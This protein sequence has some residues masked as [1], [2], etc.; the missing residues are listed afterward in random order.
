MTP[1]AM[2]STQEQQQKPTDQ[3]KSV[4]KGVQ[5]EAKPT[6]QAERKDEQTPPTAQTTATRTESFV[7]GI[8]QDGLTQKERQVPVDEPPPLPRNSELTFIG[9]PTPRP[10]DAWLLVHHVIIR[11]MRRRRE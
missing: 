11:L 8:P 2:M 5:G 7:F 3:Q 4:R 6:R 10:R 9:K 1:E